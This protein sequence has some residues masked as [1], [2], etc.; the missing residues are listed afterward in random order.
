MDN[1]I[2]LQNAFAKQAYAL[3]LLLARLNVGKNSQD[4]LYPWYIELL[5]AEE[6]A[7]WRKYCAPRPPSQFKKNLVIKPVGE[8]KDLRRLMKEAV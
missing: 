8:S 6:V 4:D 5:K 7:E 2:A 3:R 1:K